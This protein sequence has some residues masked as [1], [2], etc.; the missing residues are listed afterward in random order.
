M[1]IYCI[2]IWTDSKLVGLMVQSVVSS[3]RERSVPFLSTA[4]VNAADSAD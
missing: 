1:F 3:G 4:A 2:I